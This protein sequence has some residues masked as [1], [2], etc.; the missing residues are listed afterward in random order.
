MGRVK[1]KIIKLGFEAPKLSIWIFID[2]WLM[3]FIGA[4]MTTWRQPRGSPFPQRR[5]LPCL[6]LSAPKMVRSSPKRAK[7]L[8]RP[9]AVGSGPLGWVR[10]QKWSEMVDEFWMNPDESP[11]YLATWP[12]SCRTIHDNSWWYTKWNFSSEKKNSN[13][14]STWRS[15][16]RN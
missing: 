7:Y 3:F 16:T 4:G 15:W 13:L 12:L 2:G 1:K 6:A 9:A 11:I 10:G 14:G 5:L 8:L